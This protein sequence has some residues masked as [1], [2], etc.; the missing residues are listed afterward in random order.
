MMSIRFVRLFLLCLLVGWQAAWAEPA[1]DTTAPS[2]A[3]IL[4]QLQQAPARGLFYE[5]R[6]GGQTAYL[7]GTIHLGRADFYP[8]DLAT[9]RALAQSSE[10]VVEVDTTQTAKVQAALLQHALLPRGQTLDTVLPPELGKRL[11]TQADAQ[12]LP[13]AA[14]QPVKPWMAALTLTVGLIQ[15]TGYDPGLATDSYLIQLAKQFGKPV[16]ELESATEQFNLFDRMPEAEQLAFLEES[17]G[18]LES[19]QAQTDLEALVAAWLAS[20]EKALRQ[21]WQK[22]LRDSPRSAAWMEGAL[23]RER[24]SRMASRI[25]QMVAGGHTPFVAVGAIHLT[26]EAGLPALLQA[27]GYR[28]TNLYP[29]NAHQ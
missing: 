25:D 4:K 26:G 7:Y 18:L 21:L 23:Y 29:G 3:E 22:S 19:H 9:T 10:L 2:Q 20:D 5:V 1:P 15:E 13:K 6:K 12:G 28:V 27:K 8:L 24:N 17:L 16:A 14:I 11:N